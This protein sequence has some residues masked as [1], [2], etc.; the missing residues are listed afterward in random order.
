VELAIE[1]CQQYDEIFIIGGAT[2]YEA[3]LPKADTLYLT[4]IHQVFAGDT[5]FPEINAMEWKEIAREDI[6]QDE[7]VNFNYS[8]V[9]LEK[10]T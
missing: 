2:L 4:L 3:M 5:F 9:K 1:A 8:F 7:T 10:I 6:E